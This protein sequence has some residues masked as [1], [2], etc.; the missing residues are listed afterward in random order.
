MKKLLFIA[1]SFI[2]ILTNAQNV[3]ADVNKLSDLIKIGTENA[4]KR[5]SV[6]T[7]I[8]KLKEATTNSTVKSY[9]LVAVNSLKT[10]TLSE[11]NVTYSKDLSELSKEDLKNFKIND[12]KFK[13]IAFI[14]HKKESGKFYP[15]L[16][17]KNGVLNMRVVAY[18]SGKDWVFYDKIIFLADGKNIQ[19]DFA[20][21]DRHV[22][23]GYVSETAD[24]W[25]SPDMLAKLREIANA[26][27]V[28]MRFSGKRVD[29]GKLNKYEMQVL[30]E[31]I[32]LY[33][34]L[35]K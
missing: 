27:A 12:D 14:H 22:G 15:Y 29:D 16:S 3:D 2:A 19:F 21:T 20:D 24:E 4:S 32:E 26:K 34:K 17:V 1:I 31:I 8:E 9:S 35:K 33:D 30:K 13:G 18:Y 5:D 23:S 7:E 25:V 6:I 10:L 11:K 28:E